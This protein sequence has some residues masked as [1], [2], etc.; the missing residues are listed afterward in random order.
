MKDRLNNPW[1]HQVNIFL[2]MY[3]YWNC[4]DQNLILLQMWAAKFYFCE[5]LNFV[6]IIVQVSL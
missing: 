6:N 2:Y 5:F 3:S 4:F 1:D